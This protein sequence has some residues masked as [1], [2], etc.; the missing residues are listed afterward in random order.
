MSDDVEEINI[1]IDES[2]IQI[3][4]GERILTGGPTSQIVESSG[5]TTLAV[6]SI[7]DGKFLRRVGST[8]VGADGVGSSNSY[9]PSGW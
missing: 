2:V 8:I 3:V 1:C 4:V 9:N 5:P 7:E 6:G